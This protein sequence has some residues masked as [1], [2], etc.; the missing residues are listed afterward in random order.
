[1]RPPNLRDGRASAPR[2]L[3][4]F[5]RGRRNRLDSRRSRDG[6]PPRSQRRFAGRV[7]DGRASPEL[8]GSRRKY[9]QG[10]NALR[11]D[12]AA[13]LRKLKSVPSKDSRA[14]TRRRG[15]RRQSAEFPALDGGDGR[16]LRVAVY[17][18]SAPVLRRADSGARRRSRVGSKPSRLFRRLFVLRDY[19]APRQIRPKPERSVDFERNSDARRRSRG[20]FRRRRLKR[21]DG[22]YAR[23]GGE[24]PRT[25]RTLRPFVL[26]L[27]DPLPEP[28]RRPYRDPFA[29]EESAR[30]RRRQE[31]LDRVRNP[32]R[33]GEPLAGVRRRV[34]DLSRRRSFENGSGTRRRR[35]SALDEQTANRRLRTILRTLRRRDRSGGQGTVSRSLLDR[36]FPRLHDQGDGRGRRISS[37]Q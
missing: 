21:S 6:L 22:E 20:R 27:P 3:A 24:K 32:N 26:S 25:L 8:R 2:S 28:E 18:Q 10:Q 15:D 16:R 4:P 1:M 11:Q 13:C 30:N 14:R 31:R 29:D 7:G 17:P 37:R 23:N 36:R 9:E 34:G 33:L 35:R 12:D 5:G 19:G